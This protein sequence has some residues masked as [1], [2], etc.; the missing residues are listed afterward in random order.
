MTGVLV[1][2]H[3]TPC[4]ISQCEFSQNFITASATNSSTHQSYHGTNT[5]HIRD[6]RPLPIAYATHFGVGFKLPNNE[7]NFENKIYFFQC[8]L[9][10]VHCAY[11][12]RAVDYIVISRFTPQER[13]WEAGDQLKHACHNEARTAFITGT[14]HGLAHGTLGN[15]HLIFQLT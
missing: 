13:R 14:L 6:C 10:M 5:R 8:M 1:L 12:N 15:W 11:C 4:E 9:S 7:S 3:S 2:C